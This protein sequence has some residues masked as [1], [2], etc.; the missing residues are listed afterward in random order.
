MKRKAF[1]LIELLVVIAIIAILAAILFPVF[2]RARENARR[3]SCASNLKQ[4]GLGVLQ[5]TQDYDER[6]PYGS[7]Q[8]GPVGSNVVKFPNGTTGNNEPW[9][10]M[11]YPYVK[12][13][14]LFNCPSADKAL[15]NVGG[16]SLVYMTYSYNYRFPQ[17]TAN[18]AQ[19]Y[20]TS[21]CTYVWNCGV[22]LEGAAL[23]AIE[24]PSETIAFTEGSSGLVQFG[25]TTAG[26]L[27]RLPT[28]DELHAGGTCGYPASGN[29][30]FSGECLRARHL[31]TMN[32]LFVDGH[33]K[34]MQWKTILG[35]D[36]D[37]NVVKY[38]TTAKNTHR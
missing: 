33:V 13:L 25:T 5:Y 38:W 22:S 30:Y 37:P 26:N 32:T 16:Y 24:D 34:S 9:Y 10:L 14:Q 19:G 21:S 20:P 12:S 2:A 7:L 8:I 31:D 17:P 29:A 36:N 6:M 35:S 28:E 15:Y 27:L 23:A 4:I 11:I 3:S 1:T 18:P